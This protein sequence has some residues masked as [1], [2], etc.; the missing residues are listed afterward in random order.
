MTRHSLRPP[1]WLVPRVRAVAVSVVLCL[2][3]TGGCARFSSGARV[4]TVP[5]SVAESRFPRDAARFALVPLTDSTMSFELAEARWVRAGAE[6]VAVDP[7]RGDALVARVR[8]TE[9]SGTT[10]VALVTGQ[11]SRIDAGY[12]LLLV[13]PQVPWWRERSFW[14]GVLSGVTVVGA[15]V[16]FL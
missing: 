3:F 5:V 1:W 9:M 7:A 14:W 6:G 15:F 16:A 4:E 12:V 8:V 11:T 2:A 10:A 13:R